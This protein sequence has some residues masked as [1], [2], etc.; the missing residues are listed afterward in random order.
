DDVLVVFAKHAHAKRAAIASLL[1][2]LTGPAVQDQEAFQNG[3]APTRKSLMKD[4][5]L[6]EGIDAA[7]N[8]SR[9]TPLV[10]AWSAIAFELDAGLGR[11]LAP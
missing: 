4:A 11:C 3:S 7:Y 8:L 6:P 10:S 9:N 1:D 2:F 5:P